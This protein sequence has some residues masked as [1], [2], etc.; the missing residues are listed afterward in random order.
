M[1]GTRD[2]D[3]RCPRSS[4]HRPTAAQTLWF[5]SRSGIRG[6]RPGTLGRCP[7]KD[8]G[9]RPADAPH[10]KDPLPAMP[11]RHTAAPA[12][13]DQT[14]KPSPASE[15][16]TEQAKKS[17]LDLSVTQVLGGA[18]AAMTAAALGSRF[19]V[20]GTVVGAAL[21]SVIAAVAGSLYTASLRRTHQTVRA[22][23]G[24]PDGA[25]G[26]LHPSGISQPLPDSAAAVAATPLVGTVDESAKASRRRSL[27]LRAVLGAL[28]MFALAAGALTVYEAASGH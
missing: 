13:T 2:S 4:S 8:A 19:S 15:V 21:A 22:V 7:H 23:L 16:E 28:A 14:T 10:D 27:I 12:M 3:S 9:V 18:L 20:A 26:P 5:S 1:T 6:Y 25:V 17:V 11:E 24:R